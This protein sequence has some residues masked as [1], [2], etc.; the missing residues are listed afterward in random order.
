MESAEWSLFY[1][2]G[3]YSCLDVIVMMIYRD[4]RIDF[5]PGFGCFHELET[6]TGLHYIPSLC[7][8]TGGYVCALSSIFL[9][10][11]LSSETLPRR[12]EDYRCTRYSGPC[13]QSYQRV[14][15]TL[16]WMYLAAPVVDDVSSTC[17]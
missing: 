4:K 14:H 1:G 6:G 8:Y 16:I 5:L 17:E 11:F 12:K 2:S 7:I 3:E 10:N 13:T 9:G 15:T